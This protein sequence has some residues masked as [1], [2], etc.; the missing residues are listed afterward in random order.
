MTLKFQ[1]L[2]SNNNELFSLY[3]PVPSSIL[4]LDSVGYHNCK[5]IYS[6]G[7]T[8]KRWINKTI[9]CGNLFTTP[10]IDDLTRFKAKFLTPE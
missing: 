7:I 10:C 4:I 6:T 9:S 8:N 1:L 2:V 3:Y 5:T